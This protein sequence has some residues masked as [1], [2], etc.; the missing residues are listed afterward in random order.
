MLYKLLLNSCRNLITAFTVLFVISI[1]SNAHAY[2]GPGAGFAVMGSFF[3]LFAAFLSALATLLFWPI[4]F[5]I[6]RYRPFPRWPGLPFKHVPIP[7]NII[8]L[9]F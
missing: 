9:T 8:F 7:E 4:R 2:I 1:Y 3:A 5:V 6:L